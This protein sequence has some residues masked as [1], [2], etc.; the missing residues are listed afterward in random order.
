MTESKDLAAGVA[1]AGEFKV[2]HVMH[3]GSDVSIIDRHARKWRFE[4]HPYCGPIVIGKNGSPLEN[5]PPESSP[6]WEAVNCWYQQGKATEQ[7]CGESFAKCIKPTM[8][9]MIHLGGNHY[10]LDTS[11]LQNQPPRVET[12]H[13]HQKANIPSISGA[14]VLKATGIDLSDIAAEILAQKKA[15]EAA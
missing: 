8:P 5:Q 11:E 9:K 7:I 2:I 6:F 14:A 10:K 1:I 12:H 4:D 3:G 15:G 13:V